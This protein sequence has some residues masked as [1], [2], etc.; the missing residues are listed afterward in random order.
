MEATEGDDTSFLEFAGRD[1]YTYTEGESV[2]VTTLSYFAFGDR[3]GVAT[4]INLRDIVEADP[5]D[6]QDTACLTIVY[7]FDF[8]NDNDVGDILFLGKSTFRNPRG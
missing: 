6:G 2:T 7:S 4:E 5:K 1:R 8:D 3:D